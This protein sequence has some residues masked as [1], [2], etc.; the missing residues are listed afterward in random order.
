M[1][2]SAAEVGVQLC[3]SASAGGAVALGAATA[4]PAGVSGPPFA[5]AAVPSMSGLQQLQE[6]SC[7]GRRR[8]HSS[9]D[10]TDRRM[11]KR[12]RGR[13]P[14]LGPSSHHRE[15]H[16]RSSSSPSEDD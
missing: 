2:A 4:D 3:P 13:S 1:A 8:R 12:P 5:P 6:A 7:Y 14:S 9:S 16:C 15:R 11:K 10:G